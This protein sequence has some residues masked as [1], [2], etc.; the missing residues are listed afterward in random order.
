[1]DAEEAEEEVME[2][3]EEEEELMAG[4]D[5][6]TSEEAGGDN[7]PNEAVLPRACFAFSVPCKVLT[8][9]LRYQVE[10]LYMRGGM[11]S[12]ASPDLPGFTGRI[13]VRPS[14]YFMSWW[15]L[16]RSDLRLSALPMSDTT[17]AYAED[18]IVNEVTSPLCSNAPAS[19]ARPSHS[20]NPGHR[21]RRHGHALRRRSRRVSAAAKL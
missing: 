10:R 20:V 13:K 7:A 17:A 14:A 6:M 12:F 3:G 21:C 4:D 11:S 16:S 5:A 19:D 15:R 1:M 8:A 9:V 2:G 18:F